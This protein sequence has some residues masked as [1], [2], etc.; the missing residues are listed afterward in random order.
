MDAGQGLGGL[1]NMS[2]IPGTV[3]ASP[4][5]NIGA[6][7]AEVKDRFHA[8]TAFDFASGAT[9]TMTRPTAASATATA[10]SSMRTARGWWC[11]T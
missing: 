8:L 3:G 10:C 6:Y 2:L 7:G 11:W 9:R 5:Q 4:I 1:E